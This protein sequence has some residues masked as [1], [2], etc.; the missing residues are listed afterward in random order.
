MVEQP[1]LEP[2][3]HLQEGSAV[4]PL[5]LEETGTP[6]DQHLVLAEV[7]VASRQ[8]LFLTSAQR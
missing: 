3:S 6:M 1:P 5:A 4:A 2:T 8:T 7:R